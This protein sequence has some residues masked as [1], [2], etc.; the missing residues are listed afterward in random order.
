M[1]KRFGKEGRR[2][3]LRILKSRQDDSRTNP[4]VSV[5]LTVFKHWHYALNF[6]MQ[7]AGA[8]ISK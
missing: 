8:F 4:K 5:I 6:F 7:K 3:L 2:E 1:Q